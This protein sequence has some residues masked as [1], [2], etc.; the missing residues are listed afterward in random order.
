M[1]R[2]D[3][4][5]R[6]SE[7]V[8]TSLRR[9]RAIAVLALLALACGIASDVL[10]GT[11]WVR[12]A[13]LA[14]LAGSV[15]VVMFSV[16]VINEVLDRTR[17]QRWRVLAQYV[18]LELV[19]N[20]RLI[21]TGV[22][23]QAG[24]LDLDAA[25]PE[26]VDAN[27]RLVRDTPRLT[28]ALRELVVDE[29]RLRGLH[30]E[31]ATLAAHTGEVLGRWAGVMLNAEV[32]AELVDRHVEL[33]SDISW[34]ESLLD[35]SDPPDDHRRRRRARS[36]PAV[37]IEGGVAGEQLADRVVVITQL[38]EELDRS[39]LELALRVVPLEWWAARLGTSVPQDWRTV[40]L[41]QAPA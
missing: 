31:I 8:D 23:E 41:P 38:A 19:R 2:H 34:L 18:M 11:F 7:P 36:S 39:T 4:G 16:A 21:W 26:S 35:N 20:A 3:L 27:S 25:R 15:I 32:Y 5:P 22:L 37:Q 9:T 14:S 30:E 6:H 33:A 13:L 29:V 28:A 1:S 12:H 40:V 10:G 17:R 24:L